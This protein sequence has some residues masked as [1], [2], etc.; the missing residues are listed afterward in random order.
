[1]TLKS[2][3]QFALIKRI[4]AIIFLF[5]FVL[6]AIGQNISFEKRRKHKLADTITEL[7]QP[8][9]IYVKGRNYQL[10][11]TTAS[12]GR[13]ALGGNFFIGT[14]A[15]QGN[16]S[17]YFTNPYYL[18]YQI[19]FHFNRIIFQLDDY[20]GF[21]KVKQT[22]TFPDQL[23]WNKGKTVS[24]FALGVNLGYSLIE[25]KKIN[26]SF[27]AGIGKSFLGSFKKSDNS[28]NEPS[29]PYY[30]FGVHLDFKNVAISDDHIRLN[31]VDIYY[32][33]LRISFGVYYP[34][35]L[36][37]F[38]EYYA[39]SMFYITIGMGGLQRGYC[40]KDQCRF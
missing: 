23:E 33:S 21:C 38:P 4:L 28:K 7:I 15:F 31:D 1:M 2:S 8:D 30:K 5:S 17:N 9:S 24:S 39:G 18:G 37:K 26:V 35:H 12:T 6:P 13:F 40:S 16:I 10:F 19:N 32:S 3:F 11:D 34:T 27:F 14:S 25:R 22:M 29:L 20:I 36:P